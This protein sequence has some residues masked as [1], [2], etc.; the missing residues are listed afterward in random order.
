MLIYNSYSLEL[1]EIYWGGIKNPLKLISLLCSRFS[2]L[3]R[4]D[5]VKT[6]F[7]KL[8]K[9]RLSLVESHLGWLA[10]THSLKLVKIRSSLGKCRSGCFLIRKDP[11]EL[12]KICYKHVQNLLRLIQSDCMIR[13]LIL[14][15]RFVRILI[16]T[17]KTC[18]YSS[19]FLCNSSKPKWKSL[20]LVMTR[21]R[22]RSDSCCIFKIH[23]FGFLVQWDSAKLRGTPEDC[24]DSF[25]LPY[26]AFKPILTYLDFFRLVLTPI[27]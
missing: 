4:Q 20:K 21:W 14:T 24:L 26:Y 22:H 11:F 1:P 2:F 17:L 3:L 9:N 13:W 18:L 19:R 8:V 15:L 27:L 10:E 23:V 7:L 25:R 5:S 12:P 6:H 16:R